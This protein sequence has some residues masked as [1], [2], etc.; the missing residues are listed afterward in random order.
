MGRSMFW[1]KSKRAWPSRCMTKT[2]RKLWGSWHA[3]GTLSALQVPETSC[4]RASKAH[5]M[6]GS[7]R[8]SE[9]L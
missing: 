3:R 2:A 7:L 1:M 5:V 4:A 6:L 8:A 9:R